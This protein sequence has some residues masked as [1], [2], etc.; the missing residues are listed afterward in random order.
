[1]VT[2]GHSQMADAPIGVIPAP[3]APAAAEQPVEKFAALKAAKA[4]KMEALKTG[5]AKLASEQGTPAP[6][7]KAAPKAAPEPVE[8]KAEP[9]VEAKTEEVEAKPEPKAEA[10][11]EDEIDPKTAKGLAAIDKQAKKFREEQQA[12]RKAFESEI[13]QARADLAREQA[14][15]RAKYAPVD[16]LAKLVKRDPIAALRKL[17]IESEDE[18]EIVGRGAFPFTKAGKTDPRAAEIAQRSQKELT[19]DSE[20]SE[21]RKMVTDLHEQIATQNKQAEAKQFVEQWATEAIK[22]IPAD[23]PSLVARLHAK[24]P[25]KARQKL[26]EVGAQ[27]EAQNDGETPT[28]AE[29]IEELERRERAELEERGVD[30]DALLKPV[31]PTEKTKTPK[32]PLDIEA[33][34]GIKPIN[35]TGSRAERLAALELDLK[36]KHAEQQ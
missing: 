4:S 21:L 25:A 13:A 5:L 29:V 30:V 8:E 32:A 22:A 11:A 31:P 14:E 3:E 17:G 27:I 10:K 12:A 34:R 15:F 18:W 16:E 19:R 9:A 36:R 35:G 33:P 20:L 26:L 6:A 23:K 24:A 1:M 2:Y 7:E 28:H